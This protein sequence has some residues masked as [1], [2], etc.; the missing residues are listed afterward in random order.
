MLPKNKHLIIAM[1]VAP[2]LSILAWFATG[3]FSGEVPQPALSGS[4]YQLLEKSNCRYEGGT[5]VLENEDFKLTLTMTGESPAHILI[6]SSQYPLDR[7]LIAV[8]ASE[9]NTEP[10][11]MRKADSRG[12]VWRLPMLET[13]APEERIQLVAF[14]RGSSYFG[15]AATAFLQH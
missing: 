15:D 1:I 10:T 7:L 13:V 9:Q 4:S 11:A 8:G 6:V 14:T 3:E 2:V 5:C 12:L